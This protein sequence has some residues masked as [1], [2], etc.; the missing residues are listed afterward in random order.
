VFNAA[1]TESTGSLTSTASAMPSVLSS[2]S[3][4]ESSLS[5][6]QKQSG[7]PAVRIENIVDQL[8]E[9][10]GTPSSTASFKS[11]MSFQSPRTI[12]TAYRTSLD[13]SI[14]Q[15]PL[16]TTFTLTQYDDSK[17]IVQY[18]DPSDSRR[19]SEGTIFDVPDPKSSQASPSAENF[20]DNMISSVESLNIPEPS[21]QPPSTPSS[22]YSTESPTQP[23]EA[24]THRRSRLALKIPDFGKTKITRRRHSALNTL[25]ALEM[26]LGTIASAGISTTN[27]PPSPASDVVR[28]CS[29]ILWH[30]NFH[31]ATR[32]GSPRKRT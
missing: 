21:R 19:A 24:Q 11:A 18:E 20:M 2:E 6:P 28:S 25:S 1:K 9:A 16:R 29:T 22:V 30:R 14:H 31:S 26:A 15:S 5:P 27:V 23:T 17:E 32:C 10:C 4:P 3:I 7:S 13:T 12:D 8:R